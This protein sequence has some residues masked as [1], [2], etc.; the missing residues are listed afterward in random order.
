MDDTVQEFEELLAVQDA[1]DYAEA[2]VLAAA[3]AAAGIPCSVGEAESGGV[4]QVLAGAG[5]VEKARALLREIKDGRHAQSAA[6]KTKMEAVDL[7]R[8][9]GRRL[10]AGHAEE[11]IDLW[12][13]ALTVYPDF[14]DA[15]V[16]MGF[17]YRSLG[18]YQEALA[19]LRRAA[20]IARDDENLWV[21]L[22][23]VH[24]DLFQFDEA[25]KAFEQA[26]ALDRE[27]VRA[28]RGIGHTYLLE[29]NFARA[30]EAFGRALEIEPGDRRTRYCVAFIEYHRGRLP[31]ALE[32]VRRALAGGSAEIDIPLLAALIHARLGEFAESMKYVD[33][34]KLLAPESADV[35]LTLALVQAAQRQWENAAAAFELAVK[36]GPR[37]LNVMAWQAWFQATCEDP[38]YRNA[39]R[40]LEDAERASAL[41]PK[42]PELLSI[43]AQACFA[44][45]KRERAQAA[46][47][48]AL[49]AVPESPL[50]R[51]LAERFQ[52]R[53]RAKAE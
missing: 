26:L 47:K 51:E 10:V 33:Q 5:A 7:F 14:H 12:K 25:R 21:G 2:E 46:I 19:S 39:A 37:S 41:E 38:R 43:L 49:E 3:L 31:E 18:R 53:G 24:G 11:A 32:Q 30:L 16:S 35:Y 44:T 6:V 36:Y 52:K 20:E 45:G 15:L 22:G 34:A 50:Y 4:F 13:K 27:D 42:N 29:F 9:G 23:K 48:A 28:H 17:A 40:A 8:A 1:P